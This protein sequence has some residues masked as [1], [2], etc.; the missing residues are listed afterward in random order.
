MSYGNNY[1]PKSDSSTLFK[2]SAEHVDSL[3]QTHALQGDKSTLGLQNVLVT[4]M[5]LTQLD[6]SKVFLTAKHRNHNISFTLF[7]L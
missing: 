2:V 5:S 7:Y 3:Y 4:D 1:V 6:F